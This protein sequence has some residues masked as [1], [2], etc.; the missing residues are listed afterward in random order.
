M[1]YDSNKTGLC[2]MN[3]KRSD[4]RIFSWFTLALMSF[5]L[6]GVSCLSSTLW[7]RIT[8]SFFQK[9]LNVVLTTRLRTP[10]CWTVNISICSGFFV[11]SVEEKFYL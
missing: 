1:F 7:M 9:A 4:A 11:F 2:E 6:F 8:E 3:W 5:S 10:F